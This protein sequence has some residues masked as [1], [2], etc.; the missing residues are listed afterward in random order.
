[1]VPNLTEKP[2]PVMLAWCR[3]PRF[4]KSCHPSDQYIRGLED[5][6]NASIQRGRPLGGSNPLKQDH[7]LRAKT[8]R[9]VDQQVTEREGLDLELTLMQA[10]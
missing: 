6:T 5:M 8:R 1:M 3:G 4:Q 7:P 2:W 10:A 9:S